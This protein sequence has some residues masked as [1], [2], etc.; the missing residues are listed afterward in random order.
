MCLFYWCV[1]VVAGS[2][3]IKYAKSS[4]CHYTRSRSWTVLGATTSNNRKKNGKNYTEPWWVGA[5]GRAL[6]LGAGNERPARPRGGRNA[7]SHFS[8]VSAFCCGGFL[9]CG[10]CVNVAVLRVGLEFRRRPKLREGKC[11]GRGRARSAYQH[12]SSACA[13]LRPE[14][15]MLLERMEAGSVMGGVEA[16]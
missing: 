16:D 2:T 13:S 6:S 8:S 11:E 9:C 7:S 12:P 4:R 1:W 10:W 3:T 5:L 15:Q 14:L